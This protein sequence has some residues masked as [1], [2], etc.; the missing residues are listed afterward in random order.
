[1]KKQV[2]IRALV[3]LC[4]LITSAAFAQAPNAAAI[5]DGSRNRIEA[6]TTMSQSTMIITNKGGASS[7]RKITEYSKDGPKGNRVVIIFNSP[8]SIKD[9][10]FLTMEN[11]GNNDDR[12]IFLPSL[13]KVRRIAASDGASSFVGTDFSY[14]DI[15]ALNRDVDLDT[16]RMTGE[17]T[18][19]GNVCYVIESVPKDKTYQYS[20]AIQ[21]IDK[22][23]KVTHKMDLYDQKGKLIKRAE[24]SNLK[25]IQ[26]RLTITSI[27][28]TNLVEGSNTLIKVENLRYDSTIPESVFTT[29]YLETG[30]AR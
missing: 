2:C 3:I 10:R 9:T 28:M 15:S 29:T 17:E 11:P 5:V 27:K 18:L 1:M 16:H 4:S 21:W 22:S 20:K 24:M 8:A 19:N 25:E 23:T 7:E 26:G 6:D 13:G 14:D 30:K 12:W